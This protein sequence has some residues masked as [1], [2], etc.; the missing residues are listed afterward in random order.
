[1]AR[2][3]FRKVGHNSTCMRWYVSELG[4]AI[5]VSVERNVYEEAYLGRSGRRGVD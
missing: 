3:I 4:L 1:M 5:W 2:S